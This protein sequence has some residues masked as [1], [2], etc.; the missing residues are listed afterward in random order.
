MATNKLTLEVQIEGYGELTGEFTQNQHGWF[1]EEVNGLRWPYART[2][3]PAWESQE[4][5]AQ[6]LLARLEEEI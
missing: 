1:C 4:R 6:E 3:Q 2:V 5:A